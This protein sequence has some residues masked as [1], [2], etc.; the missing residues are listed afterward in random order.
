MASPYSLSTSKTTVYSGTAYTGSVS[1]SNTGADDVDVYFNSEA[2]P[3][4]TVPA[5]TSLPF[6]RRMVGGFTKCELAAHASTSTADV[7]FLT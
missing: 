2:S 3:S 6:N 1:I 7:S 5:G 4:G